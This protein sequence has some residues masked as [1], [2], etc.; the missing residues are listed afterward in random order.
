ME[1]IERRTRSL[2][3]GPTKRGNRLPS[4]SG[5]GGE[6]RGVVVCGGVGLGTF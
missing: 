2:E 4:K 5:G 3:H 1:Q 6:K